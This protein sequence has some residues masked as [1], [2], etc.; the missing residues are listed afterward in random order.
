MV[1]DAALKNGQKTFFH[2]ELALDDLLNDKQN[3]VVDIDLEMSL[4]MT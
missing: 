4:L 1:L 2:F 3:N